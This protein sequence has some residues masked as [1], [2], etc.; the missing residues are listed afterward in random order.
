MKSWLNRLFNDKSDVSAMR[1]M[2]MMALIFGMVAACK[3]AGP[4]VVAIFVGSAFGGKIGQK[5]LETK[6]EKSE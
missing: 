1:V 5:Y 3:G 6:S 4:D 2:S